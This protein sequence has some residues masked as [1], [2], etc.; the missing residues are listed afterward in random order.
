MTAAAWRTA[1]LTRLAGAAAVAGLVLTGCGSKT[2]TAGG[3]D[4][5]DPKAV[6]DAFANAWAGGDLATACSYTTDQEHNRLNSESLCSGTASWPHQAPRG[7][8]SCFDSQR[9]FRVFYSVDQPVN[10]F[11]IFS[12]GL[13]QNSD[14]TW[15]VDNLRE[16]SP[17]EY[18][19]SCPAP[20]TS[21]TS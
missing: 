3:V 9:F 19:S 14:G 17:G 2:P 15:S 10:R 11:L 12:P 8:S 16:Q 20:T 21:E 4:R 1:A 13:L 6:A 7:T 5:T 18:G